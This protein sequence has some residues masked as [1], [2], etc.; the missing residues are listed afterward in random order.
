[1]PDN[2]N[3]CDEQDTYEKLFE[4]EDVK[5]FAELIEVNTIKDTGVLEYKTL[6]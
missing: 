3:D 6:L 5:K 1:M 2:A 4:E